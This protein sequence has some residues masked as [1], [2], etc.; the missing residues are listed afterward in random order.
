M[1]HI[2]CYTRISPDESEIPWFVMTSANLSKGA[3]GK[4][5]RNETCQYLANYEAGIVFI[6][7]I[8]VKIMQLM[9]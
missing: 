9:N 2:Q 3:W 6:P 7:Q 8:M 4:M 1:P 5:L